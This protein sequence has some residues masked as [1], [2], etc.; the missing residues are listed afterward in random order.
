MPFSLF[1]RR[2]LVRAGVAGGLALKAGPLLADVTA[3]HP[4]V[5]ELF[6]SQSCSSCPLA[7]AFL[8]ELAAEPGVIALGWHVDYWNHLSWVDHLSSPEATARQRGYSARLPDRVYTPQMVISGRVGTVGSWREPIRRAIL[9]ARGQAAPIRVVL[10]NDSRLAVTLPEVEVG[11]DTWLWL[12]RYAGSET[13][14]VGAG[15]NRGRTL[16]Y[17]SPVRTFEP[18]SAWDGRRGSFQVPIQRPAGTLGFAVIAQDRRFGPIVA[19]GK[20]ELAGSA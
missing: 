5:V 18:V 20:L 2:Q 8:G 13:V 17:Y 3:P 6:T 4:V 19:A 15:E 12:A 16:T 1:S 14:D 10:A 9:G 11:A 7:D